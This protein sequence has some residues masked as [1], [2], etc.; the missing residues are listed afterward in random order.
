M[1]F[2]RCSFK[3]NEAIYSLWILVRGLNIRNKN[4]LESKVHKPSESWG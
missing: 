3:L 1:V 2:D 4:M